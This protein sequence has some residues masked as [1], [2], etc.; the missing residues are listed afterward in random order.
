[1]VKHVTDK[2]LCIGDV[3]VTVWF[4]FLFGSFDLLLFVS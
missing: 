4:Y 3:S 1:M 2:Q